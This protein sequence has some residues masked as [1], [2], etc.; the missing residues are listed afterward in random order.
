[1]RVILLTV[2]FDVIAEFESRSMEIPFLTP[3]GRGEKTLIFN[4]YFVMCFSGL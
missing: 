2:T 4:V 1:M 3:L